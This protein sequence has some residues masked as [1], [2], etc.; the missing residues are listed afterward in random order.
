MH[1]ARELTPASLAVI[2]RAFGDRDHTSV[3]NALARIDT[4]SAQS[5]TV[6]HTIEAVRRLLMSEDTTMEISH[7]AAAL[8]AATF[9][10]LRD[11]RLTPSYRIIYAELLLVA[12]EQGPAFTLRVQDLSTRCDFAHATVLGAL[13]RLAHLRLITLVW[14]PSS[15]RR[16]YSDRRVCEITTLPQE[17]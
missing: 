13:E 14:P 8:P 2:G 15:A 16:G 4:L 7:A 10:A 5:P 6:G 1:L 9:A 11:R 12:A 3:M 17:G